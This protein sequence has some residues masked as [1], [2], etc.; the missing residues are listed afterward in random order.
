MKIKVIS[1]PRM[2]NDEYFQYNVEFIELVNRYDAQRLNISALFEEYMPLFEEVDGA[3]LKIMKSAYTEKIK[4][5]DKRR[6]DVFRGLV[7]KCRA[8]EKHFK[9]DVKQAAIEIKI[10]FDTYGNIARKPLNEQTSAV[11]N[12]M[13]ELE[14]K[15]AQHVQTL[16]VQEWVDELRSSNNDFAEVYRSRFD[17]TAQ[18]TDV[19]LK[20]A[21]KELDRKYRLIVERINALVIVEGK[22]KY[23]DFIRALNVVIDKYNASIN[24][25]KAR[26]N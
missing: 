3:L 8:A 19:V 4:K 22:D 10:L 21:R 17:E 7:D 14:G 12:L 11:Y 6:D 24:Q 1:P 9:P 23:D 26:K 20:N 2:R 5:A 16:D 25:R 15:F 18:R 13:Q